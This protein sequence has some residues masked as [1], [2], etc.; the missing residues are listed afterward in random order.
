[1]RELRRRSLACPPGV[2]GGSV[3]VTRRSRDAEVV[4]QL[5]EVPLE[6]VAVERL[7][8]LAGVLMELHSAGGCQLIV[9][10]VSDEGVAEAQA[11]GGPWHVA[12]DAF[13]DRLVE[14]IQELFSPEVAEL[15]KGQ[16]ELAAENG[17]RDEQIAARLGEPADALAD[18]SP[19]P[20][21]DAHVRVGVGEQVFGGQEPDDL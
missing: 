14:H 6:I 15:L 20:R 16:A 2:V 5:G 13:G 10:R 8:R 21:R 19:D 12:D 18:H 9:Q 7:E 4:S 17:G 11:P 1:M 3:G